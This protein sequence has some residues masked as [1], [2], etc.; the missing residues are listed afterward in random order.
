MSCGEGSAAGPLALSVI[1]PAHNEAPRLRQTVETVCAYLDERELPAEVLIVEN[2][3]TDETPALARALAARDPRVHAL[4]T[5]GRRGKGLAVR[6][7]MLAARGE[8]VLFTDA[9]LATPIE[10]FAG[11]EN[12]LAAGA[13]IAIASRAL[14]GSDIRAHQSR[15]RETLGKLFNRGVQRLAVPGIWDTQCG[16]KLF[17]RRAARL[18]FA[19]QRLDGFAF[20][21]EA[22][23]I[24][25]RQGLTIREVPV[26]WWHMADS[27]VRMWRDGFGMLRD[28]VRIRVNAWRGRYNERPS[29]TRRGGA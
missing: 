20:D 18:V 10:E 3:S 1:I 2:A 25:R 5:G 28:L 23:F 22:L 15:L 27:K 11:L 24:A 14:P 13:D 19:R 4:D 12:A 26:V 9:D 29:A 8:R 6:T 17:T 21:V 16:F 7:G